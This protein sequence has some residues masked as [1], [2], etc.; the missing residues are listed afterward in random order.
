MLIVPDDANCLG[1]HSTR[2]STCRLPVIG[3][4]V[5]KMRTILAIISSFYSGN[6]DIFGWKWSFHLLIKNYHLRTFREILLVI[7]YM[8]KQWGV[9]FFYAFFNMIIN[10][11]LPGNYQ[12]IG[13]T[14]IS[15]LT[16]EDFSLYYF[17]YYPRKKKHQFWFW[18]AFPQ[19]VF[20]NLCAN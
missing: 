19:S 11:I 14:R 7:L 1:S 15:H 18:T 6:D 13:A 9:I 5:N 10:T 12:W 2:I 16:C 3:L 17:L 8:Q 4:A 20:V